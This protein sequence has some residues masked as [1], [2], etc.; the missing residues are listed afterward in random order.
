[1]KEHLPDDP[2]DVDV[3]IPFKNFF[4]EQIFCFFFWDEMVISEVFNDLDFLISFGPFDIEKNIKLIPM[5]LDGVLTLKDIFV[6]IK[7]F[8]FEER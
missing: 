7:T 8:L 5:K 1:M 4:R 2:V 6:D 3:V